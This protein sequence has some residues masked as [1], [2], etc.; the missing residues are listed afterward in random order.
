[1]QISGCI[2]LTVRKKCFRRENPLSIAT[3][4]NANTNITHSEMS[5]QHSH[6]AYVTGFMTFKTLTCVQSAHIKAVS[7]VIPLSGLH[8]VP[9]SRSDKILLL[10]NHTR[11]SILS[12]P[13]NALE[14]YVG[15]A[16]GQINAQQLSTELPAVVHSHRFTYLVQ[17]LK[18]LAAKLIN[19][20]P[21]FHPPPASLR[22]GMR[23]T[24]LNETSMFGNHRPVVA[25]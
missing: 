8:D 16:L 21:K 9:F 13:S 23:S 11:P 24:L 7:Q 2:V 14:Q 3:Q 4:E 6:Q 18:Q 1:M 20:M 5:V 12:E 15:K 10:D 22:R 25:Y 17:L 19:R